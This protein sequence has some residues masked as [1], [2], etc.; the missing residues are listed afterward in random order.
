M[1]DL[2]PEE[3]AKEIDAMLSE[4]ILDSYKKEQ[5]LN[6]IKEKLKDKKMDFQLRKELTYI[7]ENK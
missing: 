1:S 7:L 5:K 6:K 4:I 2:T 3:K